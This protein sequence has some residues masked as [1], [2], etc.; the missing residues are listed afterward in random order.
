MNIKEVFKQAFD[1][2]WANKL[3]SSL[4][5]LALVVGVFSV[6]VSTT[7]VAVLDNFFQ[8]TMSVMG[9]DV[10]NV[11]KTPSVQMGGR[12]DNV[13]NRQDITFET[14]ERLQEMLRL[15]ENVSPDET[16]DRTK[17][18]YGDEETDPTVRVVG[19]N[20]YYLDNNAYELRDGRNFSSEDIQYGRLLAIIGHDIQQEL[21]QNVNPIGKNIRVAGQQYRI[22]GTLDEKGS[23]FGQSQDEFLLIPYTAGLMI[24]G[25]NRNIDIQVKAP[26]M[27]FIETAMDEITG[28]MRVIRKVAPGAEND[29]EIETNDSLSGTFDQF[30]FILYAVGFVIGGITL[31]GAGIGV[32]NIMLVSVS[33]RTRE[34]GLRKAVGATKKAIVSQFLTETIF[35]C[36]LG[37]LIGIVLGILA[38]NG[39]A[40]WIETE[41]VIPIWA[42][43][44]GFFGMFII[45]LLFG[46]YPAYKAARLDPIDSL[47]YE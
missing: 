8:N 6:I 10:I 40:I 18:I 43:L 13:R 23:V 32:M 21:F 33:E 26:A 22:I 30:T 34:I 4:T 31:F 46:V 24:Y 3:R 29:F 2:L 14:A 9:G 42:V 44:T 36:Q 1:S 20:Q 17:V 7:A 5:L 19:S 16:F 45:A 28:V 35:I 41:P 37:G 47:R 25:G 27:D 12:A 39:M 38:G 15:A 11:S